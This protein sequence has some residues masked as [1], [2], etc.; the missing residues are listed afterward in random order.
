MGRSK[1][2]QVESTGLIR[3]PLDF[4]GV[5]RELNRG[6]LVVT[7]PPPFIERPPLSVELLSGFAW[8]Y[9]KGHYDRFEA[10]ELS[11]GRFG[12]SPFHADLWRLVCSPDDLVA[13]AAPRGHAKSTSVTLAYGLAN[14]LYRCTDYLVIV[15]DTF[16][17]QAVEHIRDY[18]RELTEN[19]DLIR[20]FRIKKLVKNVEGDIIIK[21]EDGVL[22]RVKGLG[23]E[24]AIRGLKWRGKRPGMFIIDDAENPELVESKLRRDKS[25]GWLMKDLIPAG[26]RGC[27][28]RM[29]GTILHHDA[30]L[31]R[32]CKGVD[33]KDKAWKS[34]VY[35]AHKSFNDFSDILWPEMWPEERLKKERQR[36]LDDN[37]SDGYSQEYLNDPTG[38]VDAYFRMEDLMDCDPNDLRA[39]GDFYAGWDFAVSKEQRADYSTCSIWKVLA[40]RRKVKTAQYRGR[41]DAKELVELILKVQVDF[42][43]RVQ[44]FERGALEKAIEPF[45]EDQMRAREVNVNVQKVT[46]NKD[47]ET[48]ARPLQGLVRRH[49]L[50]FDKSIPEWPDVEEEYLR[51]PRAAHDDIIDSDSIIAQGLSEITQAATTEEIEDEDYFNRFR[52]STDHLASMGRNATTGY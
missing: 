44:F 46:R 17:G 42:Q 8:Q 20:D 6:R 31:A 21:F 47:K 18:A 29:V 39:H 10:T 26:R 27:K 28:V 14:L 35:K 43:P 38:P 2:G 51:F 12:W 1:A 23:M 16:E 37:T 40:D 22:C 36:F 41:L 19:E 5:E 45:L 52:E 13:A 11:P 32:F 34:K 30:A 49:D 33:K 3:D 24:G 15:S 50:T 9:L 7:A 25:R 4:R 48:F